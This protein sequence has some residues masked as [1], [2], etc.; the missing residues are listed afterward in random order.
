MKLTNNRTCIQKVTT[1]QSVIASRGTRKIRRIETGA[2]IQC[3]E[4]NI[5]MLSFYYWIAS[6]L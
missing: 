6:H 3:R 2:A 5:R 1:Q 4:H